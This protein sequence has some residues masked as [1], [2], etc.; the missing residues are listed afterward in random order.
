MVLGDAFALAG[1]TS[2]Y[3]LEGFVA[4]RHQATLTS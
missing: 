2:A 3:S 4:T 1:V